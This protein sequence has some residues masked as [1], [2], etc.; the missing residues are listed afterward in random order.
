[1]PP[2]D[3]TGCPIIT[4]MGVSGCGKTTLGRALAA[5]LDWIYREGDEFHPPANVEKMRAGL[6]LNDEDRLPWLRAI[7]GWIDAHAQAPAVIACSALKREYRDLL[8]KGRPRV[9]FLYLRVPRAELERRVARRHHRYMPASLLDSQLATLEEPQVNEP[10]VI[11][12]DE[13]GTI[14][15]TVEAALHALHAQGLVTA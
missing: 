3:A 11:T 12:L 4:V 6:P 5:R 8:R 2:R 9:W 14:E 7:A 1:M 13:G 10:R 15:A